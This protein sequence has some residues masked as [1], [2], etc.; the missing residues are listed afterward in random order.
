LEYPAPVTTVVLNSI[1]LMLDKLYSYQLYVC[2]YAGISV[3]LQ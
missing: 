1:D 2:I 3:T